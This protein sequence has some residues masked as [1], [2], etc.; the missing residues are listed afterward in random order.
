MFWQ[1]RTTLERPRSFACRQV[2]HV[3]L[4]LTFNARAWPRALLF[5]LARLRTGW[6]VLECLRSQADIGKSPLT[7]GFRVTGELAETPGQ[8]AAGTLA[9]AFHNGWVLVQRMVGTSGVSP[10]R[11]RASGAQPLTGRRR[12]ARGAFA[13]ALWAGRENFFS[14]HSFP[15]CQSVHQA[16]SSLR[17]VFSRA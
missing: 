10:F 11:F 9:H 4:A 15:S 17:W 5:S 13:S 16:R 12:A 1:R 7:A 8:S 3:E 14:S 6:T 2:S